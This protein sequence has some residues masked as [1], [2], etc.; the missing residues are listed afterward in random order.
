MLQDF[1]TPT[2]NYRHRGTVTTTGT[3]ASHGLAALNAFEKGHDL[4]QYWRLTLIL[5]MQKMT[6][7]LDQTT[8]HVADVLLQPQFLICHHRAQTDSTSQE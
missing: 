5:Q 2:P 6:D 3:G 7:A 8:S 4:R 1:V